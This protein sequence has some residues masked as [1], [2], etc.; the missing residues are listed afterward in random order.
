[1]GGHWKEYPKPGSNLL[2]SPVAG[3][4][5]DSCLACVHAPMLVMDERQCARKII[6][7]DNDRPTIR[8]QYD[9]P[10]ILATA[11]ARPVVVAAAVGVVAVVAVADAAPER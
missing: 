3:S 8:S 2:E 11:A 6:K 10:P 1:M 4:R 7:R 9:V 5:S